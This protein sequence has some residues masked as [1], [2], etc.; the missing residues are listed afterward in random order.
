MARLPGI[1]VILGL[2]LCSR[3]A[4]EAQTPNPNYVLR[5]NP[6]LGGPSGTT[7]DVQCLQDIL[8]GATPVAAW[9]F[10]VCHNYMQVRPIGIADGITVLTANNGNVVDFLATNFFPGDATNSGGVTQ[11]VVIS[12][13]GTATLAPGT[14]Y[15][16]M[17]ITYELLAP[18]GTTSTI[19]YCDTTGTTIPSAPPVDTLVVVNGNSV[20]P[21]LVPGPIDIDIIPFILT[22]ETVGP[23][24]QGGS[25]TVPI[26]L[27][28]SLPVYG[29]SFGLA[30]S[31]AALDLVFVDQGA[32]LLALQ[33]GGADFFGVST[34][35]TGGTGFTVG[36]LFSLSS[37]LALPPG[38]D[39][40][41]VT[42]D[43]D[44]LS[45]APV[46]NSPLTFSSSLAPPAPAP[47]VPV[48]VSIGEDTV[49]PTI[50]NGAVSITESAGV[51][52]IRGDVNNSGSIDL[53]DAILLLGYQFSGG[54]APTCLDSA[55]LNDNG[56]ID[57][58]DPI[59]MLSY[60]FSAGPPPAAPFPAC[61]ED[62]SGDADGITC[63]QGC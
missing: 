11:G 58:S 52:F 54:A 62:P 22:A 39:V 23:V 10:G 25:V 44:V 9:S 33:P 48:V 8:P 4:L 16:M 36:A 17:I 55:D 14:G 7:I 3:G 31:A 59:Y 27:A 51:E 35:P 57:L 50:V 24:E 34:S 49:V 56:A 5:F 13:F 42:A 38:P 12:F 41:I 6:N 43:Y 26:R 18:N 29:F 53:S 2:A 19:Q 21:V 45:S 46:G 63:L 15:E 60:S 28:N 30:H 40:E 1:I 20:I 61:G 37:N 32:A 47:P